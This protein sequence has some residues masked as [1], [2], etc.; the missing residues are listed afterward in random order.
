MK[1]RSGVAVALLAS[2]VACRPLEKPE[3]PAN[4]PAITSFTVD[5]QSIRRGEVVTFS[6]SVQGAKAVELVDQSG[7]PVAVTFD[8]LAGTGTA[9]SSPLRSAFYVLRASGDGGR[10]AAFVQVAVDAGLKSVFLVVVPQVVK[11]GERVDLIWSAADGK[12]V[13]LVA[14]TRVISVLESGATSESPTFTTTY[15]LS[16]E[17]ADGSLSQQSATV[18]V[19]PI[20]TSFTATPPAARPGE[21]ITLD[22]A[23]SGADQVVIEEATFGRLIS[24]TTNVDAGTVEFTVPAFFADAGL[25][26]TSGDDAGTDAG[27]LP[28]GGLLDGGLP[29][30]PNV[31]LV[32]DGFP[33]RFTL[34][35]SSRTPVQQVQRSVEARVGQGP[36]IDVFDAPAIASR[37]LPLR[38][39]WRTSGAARIELQANGLPI[40]SPLAGVNVSGTFSL[41]NFSADTTFTL[42]AYDFNGLS[43][44]STRRVSTVPLPRITSFVLPPSI[45][46]ATMRATATWTTADAT[47]LLLRLK[48]GPAFFREDATLNVTNGTTQFTVPIKG[49]YV[50][51]AYN[52]A[53]DRVV[54]ERLV[55]VEAPIA[56]SITPDL[57]ARGEVTTVDWD[58]GLINPTDLLGLSAPPPAG[59]MNAAAFDDIST[60]PTARTLFFANRADDV[61]TITFPNGFVFPFVTRQARQVT[62]SIN[63][64]M[65]F[66]TAGALPTNANLND[67]GY[68]GPPLLAPFWDDLDLGVDG[69]VLWNFDDTAYPRRVTIQWDKVK[70][71][72][73]IGSELTFQVQLW[74]TGKFSFAW[75]QLDGPGSDGASATIGAVDGV[76][77]YQGLVAFEDSTSAALA[78]NTERVWFANN[79]AAATGQRNYRLF[80]P[81]TLGFV[82]DTGSEYVPVYGRAR[83]FGI[84]DVVVNEAMPAPNATLAAG[85]WIE[86]YNPSAESLDLAGLRLQSASG[87]MAPFNVPADTTVDAGSYLVV[88]QSADS[89]ENG[90][91]GVAVGW[92][93]TALPLSTPDS[94]ALVLPTPLSDGGTLVISRLT[95][96]GLNSVQSDGGLGADGGVDVGTSVQPPENVLSRTAGPAF[97]CPRTKTFGTPT[98]I[99]TPGGPNEEC[100]PY[101]LTEI[102]VNFEN[103]STVSSPLFSSSTGFDDTGVNVPLATPFPYFGQSYQSLR[104]TTNGWVS[105][106]DQSSASPSN[107]AR[108]DAFA[109]LGTICPFW[110]DLR[111]LP[112]RSADSNVYQAR[113]SNRTIVQWNRIER[114]AALDDLTFEVKLFDNGVIEFHYAAMISAT[115]ANNA[116]GN[117]A[118]VWIENP[119]GTQAR[120]IS[121]NQ[122]LIRP[123]SAYR[124]TPRA[125][126]TP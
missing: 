75:R 77:V 99:G 45:V 102:P 118:T 76:D 115:Q 26:P 105:L 40:Y 74:E 39:T 123:F 72:G 47:F 62:V 120:A 5:K 54:A 78:V 12:N 92:P 91:A 65:A 28:D 126:V 113:L 86:L 112:T 82:V 42:V 25:I 85:Q 104:I 44:Q 88:G 49:T 106:V 95:W 66:T 18:T 31:P 37:G 53:G 50:L 2:A 24:T 13:R 55:D 94:V 61:A 9:Q 125:L 111:A 56:L 117:G 4:P 34:T 52:S 14:G 114:Y 71:T 69:K 20:V 30:L 96:G 68:S 103:V 21:K 79:G 16:G 64:F 19:T 121:V 100:F 11:P 22:W 107:K 7:V 59:V 90:D 43:V 27:L 33:L 46:T 97:T 110:D 98:Q 23:T 36:V 109:P 58:V 108:P 41:G 101:V 124:F 87:G 1:I 8:D 3:A 17:R 32:R 10:D 57:L 80:G 38:L 29:P 51:E 122:P 70:K 81:A 6:F 73:E 84:G 116:N 89:A 83:A 67:V 15:T 60:A 35:A 93:L 63:G 119:E 48:N